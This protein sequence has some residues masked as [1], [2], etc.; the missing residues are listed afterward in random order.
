MD[1]DAL[2][3]E[4]AIALG[5]K[6][7]IYQEGEYERLREGGFAI[8]GWVQVYECDDLMFDYILPR[9]LDLNLA[10]NLEHAGY[11]LKL[12]RWREVGRPDTWL[13]TYYSNAKA[14]GIGRW[15]VVPA[16]AICLAWLEIH[17]LKVSE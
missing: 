14:N 10:I 7:Q 13:A 17:K 9:S 4:V 16:T 11:N 3:R 8:T 2:N 15:D 6:P 5:E 1:Y 12:E